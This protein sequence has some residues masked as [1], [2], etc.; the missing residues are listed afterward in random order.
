MK[1]LITGAAGA[2]GSVLTKEWMDLC[3]VQITFCNDESLKIFK[4]FK[5]KNNNDTY[6]NIKPL[7]F[8]KLMP[9][10]KK[11]NINL[12]SKLFKKILNKSTKENKIIEPNIVNGKSLTKYCKLEEK[13]I[14]DNE[15]FSIVRDEE[16]FKWRLIECPY[17]SDIYEFNYNQDVFI[18][19]I[20]KSNNLKRLNILYTY[21]HSPKNTEIFNLIFNWCLNNN[22]DF[23]WSINSSEN[24]IFKETVLDDLF[25]KKKINYACW[26]KD[27][28]KFSHLE[29]GLSNSQGSDSDLDSI[30]YQDE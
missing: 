21:I 20:F 12:Q 7:N 3:P 17:N 4:K 30:L 28:K 24:K 9:I 18:C 29:K 26:A 22:I 1:V 27:I 15:L 5:W 16:W 23:I 11:F 14:L 19:H 10:V 2:I 25:L 8:F 6:R 13:K